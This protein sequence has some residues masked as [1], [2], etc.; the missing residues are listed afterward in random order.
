M[1][2]KATRGRKHLLMLSNV[3]S[4][5]LREYETGSRRQKQLAKE[6]VINL[7]HGTRLDRTVFK[8][9][10]MCNMTSINIHST[11]VN[12]VT[13]KTIHFIAK[14]FCVCRNKLPPPFLVVHHT[15][16]IMAISDSPHIV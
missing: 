14:I 6:I 13:G 11:M 7:P 15:A 5:R 9:C 1:L 8:H 10:L 2:G 4:K 3:I 16:P 12:R